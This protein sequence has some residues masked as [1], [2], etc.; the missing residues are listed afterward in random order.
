MNPPTDPTFRASRRRVLC[1]LVGWPAAALLSATPLRA[2][3]A[4]GDRRSIALVSTHTGEQLAADYYVDGGYHADS[5]AALDRLLRDHRTGAVA[6]IDHRLYD[7]LHELATLA[8]REPSY[9]VI[10]GY[11]SPQTNAALSARSSGVARHSLH[12]DGQAIDVRLTGFATDRLRDLALRLQLGGVG[13]YRQSDFL[14]LDT[15]RVRT[16]AG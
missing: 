12:M 13:Y 10:S 7:L 6:A 14:H 3:A 11:R 4:D 5:L 1:A 16:W 2:L 8:G 15:G 9:E